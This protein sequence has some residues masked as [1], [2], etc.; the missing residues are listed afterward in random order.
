[1]LTIHHH[2]PHLPKHQ[3][4][5]QFLHILSTQPIS[6]KCALCLIQPHSC[7]LLG[8][9]V[10]CHFSRKKSPFL[11]LYHF[12]LWVSKCIINVF[13]RGRICEWGKVFF[14]KSASQLGGLLQNK[15][16]APSPYAVFILFK[17]RLPFEVMCVIVCY[18]SSNDEKRNAH[19]VR[20]WSRAYLG[21]SPFCEGD[22]NCL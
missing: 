3:K 14:S 6:P 10:Q 17:V 5:L 18:W 21:S 19:C 11:H 4:T 7:Q 22:Q 20:C 9:N 16:V 2:R 1:V 15:A 8:N 13:L 12:I